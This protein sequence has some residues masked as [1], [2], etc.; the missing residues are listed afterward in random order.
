MSD[1]NYKQI[2]SGNIFIT[3][4]IKQSLN[5]IGVEPV[6]KDNNESGRLAGFGTMSPAMQEVYVHENE[7]EKA[8]EVVKNIIKD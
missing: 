3:Q 6:I 1:S 4:Q 7:Y 5:E 8:I 2:Y